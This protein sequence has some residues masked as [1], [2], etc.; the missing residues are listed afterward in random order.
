MELG[1]AISLYAAVVATGLGFLKLIEFLSN[2]PKISLSYVIVKGEDR[3]LEELR[4]HVTN[5]GAR[6][7]TVTSVGVGMTRDEPFVVPL[8][9]EAHQI[10]GHGGETIPLPLPALAT[11]LWNRTRWES[12]A[13]GPAE[14]LEAAINDVQRD[15]ASQEALRRI[16]AMTAP[17]FHVTA[18]Y[19]DVSGGKRLE[20]EVRDGGYRLLVRPSGTNLITDLDPAFLEALTTQALSMAS[21]IR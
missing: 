1:D 4:V 13:S 12:P 10:E 6:Q 3:R 17:P 7:A 18:V 16:T 2:R 20:V 8:V 9:H 19:A 14:I 21:R 15:A 5:G 11:E